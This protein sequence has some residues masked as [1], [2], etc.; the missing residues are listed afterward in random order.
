[1][2]TCK[3]FG[4]WVVVLCAFVNSSLLVVLTVILQVAISAREHEQIQLQAKYETQLAECS[5]G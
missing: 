3:Q 5:S 2:A 4:G 1:V